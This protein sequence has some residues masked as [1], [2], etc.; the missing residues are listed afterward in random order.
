MAGFCRAAWN[1]LRALCLALW[2][3]RTTAIGTLGM[4]VAT[5]ESWLEDH[6]AFKLPHRGTILLAFGAT[7]T[8]IGL[9]NKLREYLTAT[10]SEP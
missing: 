6:P 7:V 5:A 2:T 4:I 9:Y 8:A 3:H 10:K 1:R